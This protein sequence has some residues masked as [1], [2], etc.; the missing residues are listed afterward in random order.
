MEINE[1][2]YSDNNMAVCF[3]QARAFV[4]V[5][6]NLIHLPKFSHIK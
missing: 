3:A 2:Y 6:Y 5:K 1:R 4:L